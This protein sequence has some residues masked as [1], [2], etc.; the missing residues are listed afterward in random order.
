MLGNYKFK[1][2]LGD[3]SM[4]Q[5]QGDFPVFSFY[6]LDKDGRHHLLADNRIR[7]NNLWVIKKARVMIT[8]F[9]DAST[10]YLV[11]QAH[12]PNFS[13]R[14]PELPKIKDYP[15]QAEDDIEI[16]AG[17]SNEVD[18]ADRD[19]Q[20]IF[21]GSIDIMTWVGSDR[22]GVTLSVQGRDRMK[23][24]MD[25][26]ISYN[27]VT[28]A[29]DSRA[30][31]AE[32][33]RSG[34]GD[35]IPRSDIILEL[36]Q[37]GIGFVPGI[38]T[39][40]KRAILKGDV[41]DVS[42]DKENKINQPDWLYNSEDLTRNKV[43]L[44]NI[45][46][47]AYRIIPGDNGPGIDFGREV[48][49]QVSNKNPSF[50]MY[51]TRPGFSAVDESIGGIGLQVVDQTPIDYIKYLAQQEIY[52]TELF[53]DHKNGDIYYTPRL[54]DTIGLDY[55]SEKSKRRLYRTYF[56]RPESLFS[57]LVLPEDY[58][59]D[60][61]QQIL[62]LKEES[63]SLSVRTNYI[64]GNSSTGSGG[65]EVVINFQSKP[66]SWKNRDYPSRYMQINDE[67]I[68]T[69][70][71][72]GAVAS[73]KARIFSRDTRSG[74]MTIQGDPTFSPGEC[75]QIYGSLK[76]QGYSPLKYNR[77]RKAFF[78]AQD[79]LKKSIMNLQEKVWNGRDRSE[80]KDISEEMGGAGSFFNEENDQEQE[81]LT[82]EEIN[83]I[84][85]EE[86]LERGSQELTKE[87]LNQQIEDIQNRQANADLTEE[88][89]NQIDRILEIQ[90]QEI[91]RKE[92]PNF[93]ID[94]IKTTNLEDDE[95][96]EIYSDLL[97]GDLSG[98]GDFFSANEPE[99]IYRVEAII[100]KLSDGREGY[101]TELSLLS[102]F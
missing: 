63:S 64:V 53:Q 60:I 86:I 58:S 17:Y 38:D 20:R 71:E 73:A 45:D 40:A 78:V 62:V 93:T 6:G 46:R 8:R 13:S 98:I 48:T 90:N 4:K 23:W 44:S 47:S 85:I 31:T 68:D 21:I 74:M 77:E 96:Q 56:Y 28:D 69:A 41:Y 75:V 52:P 79:V 26:T 1:E 97:S 87:E 16:W 83:K 9:W 42:I 51:V 7:E 30:F 59:I 101:V 84:L 11:L 2:E 81:N 72:A 43:K 36:A 37:R 32:N 67:L 15:L 35:L 50:N 39:G 100:H 33:I 14:I 22:E 82:K 99:S 66:S 18:V 49:D 34:E 70:F 27:A 80:N 55:P 76:T 12:V 19:F 95:D 65:N 94:Q 102:P 54:N 10:F 5:R 61:R 57:E 29:N 25:S 89:K 3:P 92:N 91:Q 88:E 24:L